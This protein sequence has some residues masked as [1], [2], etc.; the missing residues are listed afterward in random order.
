MLNLNKILKTEKSANSDAKSKLAAPRREIF[1][2]LNRLKQNHALIYLSLGQNGQN[3][4]QSIILDVDA[5]TDTIT[6]DELFPNKL[7]LKIGDQVSVTIRESKHHSLTFHTKVKDLDEEG[8]HPSYILSL[9]EYVDSHQRR[10][11]FRLPIKGQAN[12]DN[13]NTLCKEA[14]VED[15]SISGVKLSMPETPLAVG[16]EIEN[17]QLQFSTLSFTCDLKVTRI[18]NSNE[19]PD[20]TTIGARM[21]TLDPAERR[22]LEQFLMQ[23]QR[24]YRLRSAY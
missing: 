5:E 8:D 2:A 6:I 24:H 10:E 22:K 23:Q 11:A 16:G 21:T 9:P 14:Q 12:W 1:A 19:R 3:T 17:C 20:V 7:I 18:D 13:T 4:Y 15:I